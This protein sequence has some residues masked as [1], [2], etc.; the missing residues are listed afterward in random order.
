ME[1]VQDLNDTSG[2]EGGEQKKSTQQAVRLGIWVAVFGFGIFLLWSFLVPISKGIVASGVIAVDGKRKTIQHLEGGIVR[3]IHVREGQTVKAGD[4]LI[5]LD[6]TR[7]R[8]EFELLLTRY[9]TAIAT[10]DRYRA[11][12]LSSDVISFSKD[13]SDNRDDPRVIELM[14]IQNN[15]LSARRLQL[16]GQTDILESQIQQLEAQISGFE[17]ERLARA[18]QVKFLEDEVVR[19]T[20]LYDDN[21]TELSRLNQVRI[22]LAEAQGQLG[23][24]EAR[25]SASRVQIGEARLTI[26][27]LQNERLQEIAEG[28]LRTQEIRFQA[29]EQLTSVRSVLERTEIRAPQSG[30]VLNL[31]VATLGGVIAPGA[32]LMD[33]VPTENRLVIEAQVQPV[34]IDSVEQ[35]MQARA[36]LSAL[37]AR[38]TPEVLG[39]VTVVGADTVIDEASQL[40]Y[41]MVRVDIPLD[42]LDKKVANQV[43]PGMPVELMIESGSRTAMQ[44][45]L[46]PI[47]DVLRRSLRE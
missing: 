45:F 36:R 32:P 43:V 28:I 6:E 30:R 26:L 41:Y 38:T 29:E 25:Q 12:R 22:R 7:N 14:Q 21:L 39:R 16:E 9:Y 44:Y 4:L 5:E 17:R 8:A 13:L 47:T 37:N 2:D 34:D 31:V 1:T 24:V 18:D 3:S 46:E 40:P 42:V 33:I 27:Q 20:G 15:L 11:E 19:L 10:L 23:N 35:G